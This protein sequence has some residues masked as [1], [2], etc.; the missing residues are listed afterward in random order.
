MGRDC[1]PDSREAIDWPDLVSTSYSTHL[2]CHCPCPPLSFHRLFSFDFS[3]V[4]SGERR[5]F[6]LGRLLSQADCLPLS[7]QHHSVVPHF[8]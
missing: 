6:R 5:G 3:L 2:S 1:P 7:A 4:T 8:V